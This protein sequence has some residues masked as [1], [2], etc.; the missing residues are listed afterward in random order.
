M[1]EEEDTLVADTP[2]V[3]IPVEVVDNLVVDRMVGTVDR[4]HRHHIADPGRR[5]L[6]V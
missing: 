6:Q 1:I 5:T 3:G 2:A 4:H